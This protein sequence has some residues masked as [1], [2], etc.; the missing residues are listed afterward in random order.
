MPSITN[1]RDHYTVTV[2]VPAVYHRSHRLLHVPPHYPWPLRG[3]P[4][5]KQPPPTPL[6]PPVIPVS[7]NGGVPQGILLITPAICPIN[8]QSKFLLFNLLCHQWISFFVCGILHNTRM[9]VG[10][11]LFRIRRANNDFTE[12]KY[13]VALFQISWVIPFCD[14]MVKT[15]KKCFAHF[16]FAVNKYESVFEITKIVYSQNILAKGRYVR[17]KN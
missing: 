3:G 4:Q 8:S 6:H 17:H 10:R 9:W 16:L 1:Q 15:L 7:I 11:W 14:W 12:W 2:K 5:V 13:C